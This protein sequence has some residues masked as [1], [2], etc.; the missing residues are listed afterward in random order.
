MVSVDVKHDVYLLTHN[1]YM[2]KLRLCTLRLFILVG[3]ESHFY[4]RH[5]ESFY[6]VLQN[7]EKIKIKNKIKI[8]KK[9]VKKKSPETRTLRVFKDNDYT[10]GAS[11]RKQLAPGATA[12]QNSR[13]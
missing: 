9:R 2:P 6:A 13:H 11:V 12:F 5:W 4:T 10:F 7:I 1:I 8:N 3:R